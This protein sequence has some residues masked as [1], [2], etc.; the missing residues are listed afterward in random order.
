MM[1]WA[2]EEAKS[3]SSG[4]WLPTEVSIASFAHWG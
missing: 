1:T 4:P 3:S 2:D